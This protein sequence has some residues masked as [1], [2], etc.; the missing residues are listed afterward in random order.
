M[1]TFT[2]PTPI[3]VAIKIPIGF[4]EIVAT[5]RSDTIVTVSPTNPA[6]AV[7]VRG[8]GETKVD[9]DGE[10]LTITGP[11]PRLSF[12]GPFESIDVKVEVPTGSRLTVENSGGPVRSTGLL[13]ATRVK[14]STV[15]LDG[16]GDLWVRALNGNVTVANADGEVEITADHGQ[17]RIGT[18]T[19]DAMLKASHGS[20][21]I[22][23]SRGDLEAKLAYGDLEI[24]KALASVTA[25]TAYGSIALRDVS[26]GAM[27]VESGYG[28]ISIGIRSGVP[29]WLDLS[30]KNGRVRNEL[31]ADTA[32]EST[33]E[34]VAVRAR[35][36]FGDITIARAG[37][38]Q[39]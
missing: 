32:P 12:V 11:R 29:A 14:S 37:G 34:S 7:D 5:D 21:T 15:D 39:S 4:V 2:T 26:R 19:G 27:Q 10:R 22:T 28:Q 20:V 31:E 13:G 24:T 1:P 6:K 33:D 9:F 16:T 18:V 23:E 38:R 17:I 25:K 36:Q 35:T 8:A 3:D 30:S